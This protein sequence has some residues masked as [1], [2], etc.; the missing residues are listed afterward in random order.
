MKTYEVT[1]PIAGHAF[2]TV[3]ANSEEEAIEIA[4]NEVT[5]QDVENW[6]CLSKFNQGNVCYC[7][8]PWQV[9][10]TLGFGEE[11]DEQN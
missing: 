10:A 9:E 2:R 3:Q 4:M 1:I 8:H 7:P 11:E 6:D 5:L